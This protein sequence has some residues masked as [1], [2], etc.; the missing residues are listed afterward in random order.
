M[1]KIMMIASLVGLLIIGCSSEPVDTPEIDIAITVDPN[2]TVEPPRPSTNEEG[3]PAPADSQADQAAYPAPTSDLPQLDSSE[4]SSPVDLPDPAPGLASIG[5]TLVSRIGED[6]FT[7]IQPVS[8]VLGEFLRDSN[9]ELSMLAAGDTYEATIFPTGVFIFE[10]VPAGEYG[11]VAD[12]GFAKLPISESDGA[13]M[14][15]SVADGEAKQLG[16][17]EL[18]VPLE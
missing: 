2:L 17:V 9:G 7:P 4:V 12:L 6:S 11:L 16:L 8:L 14:V 13:F 1:K 18:E 10:G 3:Y 5:G 15:I